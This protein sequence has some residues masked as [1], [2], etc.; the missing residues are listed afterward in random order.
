MAEQVFALP[1]GEAESWLLRCHRSGLLGGGLRR[2]STESPARGLST[3]RS[4]RER[5]QLTMNLSG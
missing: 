1:M 5:L 2:H 4:N 3:R